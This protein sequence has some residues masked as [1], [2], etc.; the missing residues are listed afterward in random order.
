[1]AQDVVIRFVS[2]D[3]VTQTANKVAGSIEKVD[4]AGKSAGKSFSNLTS[5]FTA[6]SGGV[7]AVLAL[8]AAVGA[9]AVKATNVYDKFENVRKSLG[10]MTGS[11]QIGDE[12][13]QTMKNLAE[14]TPFS[15]DDIAQGTQKLLAMG[16][17]AEQIPELMTTIGD[18]AAATGSGADGVNRITLAL[19]QMQAKGKI[20]TEEMM[21]LQELGIPAFQLLA[22]A[23]GYTTQELMDM[24]SKGIVP[25][26]ENMNILVDAMQ[27]EY[28]GMMAEQMGTATQAQSNFYDAVDNSLARLGE[29]LSPATISGWGTMTTAINGATDAT[30]GFAD[31]LKKAYDNYNYNVEVNKEIAKNQGWFTGMTV[32]QARANVDARRAQEQVNQAVQSGAG[33]TY[34]AAYA[35]NMYASSTGKSTKE[36]VVNTTAAKGSTSANNN[37]ANSERQLKTAVDSL[38]MSYLNIASAQRDVKRTREAL[39]DAANP[40]TLEQ[41]AIAADRAFYNNELLKNEITR[42]KTR[43]TQVRKELERGSLTQEERNALMVEDAQ[44][45]EDLIGKNLDMRESVINLHKAQ[46]DLDR[47]RDPARIEEYADAHTVANIRLHE[48]QATQSD[49]ITTVE[50]LNGTLGA[51][52]NVM[53]VLGN[54]ASLTATPLDGI[55][56][57]GAD[58]T[59]T[60]G[61]TGGT[62]ATL[63]STATYVQQIAVNAPNASAGI[64]KL[65]EAFGQL[66]VGNL[67]GSSSSLTAIGAAFGAISTGVYNLSRSDM[68]TTLNELYNRTKP[69]TESIYVLGITSMASAFSLL[70][71]SIKLLAG[72]DYNKIIEGL[73]GINPS[74][75][76]DSSKLARLVSN[77]SAVSAAL[78]IGAESRDAS[79]TKLGEFMSAGFG[80][81]QKWSNEVYDMW[82]FLD[83][84]NRSQ[85]MGIGTQT[86]MS[87]DT[88]LANR[89]AGQSI[90]INL[91]YGN[92]PDSTNPLRDVENYIQAQGGLLRI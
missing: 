63:Q 90:V 81:S 70:A 82:D 29:L 44:I 16:F 40:E 15:F 22:D 34:A 32:E 66:N 31:W 57:E 42:M 69:L 26:G 73:A 77:P 39:E 13:F 52:V 27:G 71:S 60:Y 4:S 36:L 47:A 2:Q 46:K 21:Q 48:L 76:S 55:R 9:V 86:G 78:Y 87:A 54:A 38:R 92:A 62:N 41:Y 56:V 83:K 1:M 80:L 74:M 45:T 33:S 25:A 91:N 23:T 11:K 28:G 88:A 35:T 30:I 12:L 5:S 24:V 20:T 37:L 49:T 75:V 67:T 61:G 58:I 18:T 72:I 50:N 64:G 43:Q 59:K 10:L 51:N 7:T 68:S 14:R 3:N 53:G 89:G 19:G 17:A 84:N 79:P 65:N 6:I 8:G 85:G